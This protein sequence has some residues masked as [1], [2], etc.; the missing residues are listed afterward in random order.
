[1]ETFEFKQQPQ[2]VTLTSTIKNLVPTTQNSDALLREVEA[3]LAKGELQKKIETWL[4]RNTEQKTFN[5]DGLLN[6]QFASPAESIAAAQ[7]LENIVEERW[8]AGAHEIHT[9]IN[10]EKIKTF[11]SDAKD[12]EYEFMPTKVEQNPTLGG[13]GRLVIGFPQGANEQDEAHDH[14]GG[15]I[16]VAIKQPGKF[17]CPD[18][19][20]ERV[21]PSG[22]AILMPAK[23]EHNFASIGD[24]NVDVPKDVSVDDILGGKVAGTVFLSFHLGYVDVETHEALHYT[25]KD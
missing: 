20:R 24:R 12:V 21:M 2:R 5:L 25:K 19:G 8:N 4:P 11:F 1:M 13:I 17:N 16:V 6:M 22:T 15:R 23:A 7:I 18:S 3:I 9:E 10:L 14:P